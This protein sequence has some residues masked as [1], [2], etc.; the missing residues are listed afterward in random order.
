MKTV[1]FVIGPTNAGKTTLMDAVKKTPNWGTVEVGRM[2][3]AKYPP[4]FFAGQAAPKHT[5]VE[6]WQMCL[7]GVR[8]VLL[9]QGKDVVF[10]DGQPRD[11]EQLEKCMH[12]NDHLQAP[13]PVKF[14]FLHLFAARDI[15][16]ARAKARDQ[17][18]PS[19]L[20]LSMARLDGD[21]PMNYE[22]LSRLLADKHNVIVVDTGVVNAADAP[23]WPA[24]TGIRP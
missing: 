5:A 1:I 24:L 15:R 22:I 6:A 21:V 13:E 20:A 23:V 3:R 9:V 18:D 2:L 8:D 11:L 10:V 7:D 12:F 19:K 4:E 16:E 14:F 17:H